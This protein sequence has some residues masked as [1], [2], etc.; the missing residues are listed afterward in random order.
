MKYISDTTD[1]KLNNSVVSLG[2]FDG[3][4]KGHQ[5]LINKIIDYKKEGYTSVVFSFLYHPYNLFN[6]KEINL[7]YTEEEKRIKLA[8]SGL[9]VLVS[10]PFTEETAAIEP[11]EFIKK[12]LIDTLDAKIVVVGSDFRFGYKRKGDVNLLDS[13][14]LKYGYKLVVFEKL[15]MNHDTVGSSLIRSEIEK[16]NLDYVTKLL[17]KPYS[18]I[19][20]VLHGR[21][22]GRTLGMPTTNLIPPNNKLLPPNGV[23]ASKTIIDQVEYNSVTNI[24]CNPTV[25]S[26]NQKTI[27]TY[28]FDFEGDLYGK[29]IEVALYSFQ[30]GEAKFKSLQELKDQMME[31][32]NQAKNYLVPGT[33]QL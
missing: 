20:E 8:E 11:E 4:H 13:L 14:S 33:I 10:Y 23:Y 29:I 21:K 24:G 17:G 3:L 7:I 18:I 5:L 28:I 30:R 27:E 31:D 16:G 25:G 2:K 19:G 6:A 1:F 26:G 15:K 32:V 12:I 9:D 22:I